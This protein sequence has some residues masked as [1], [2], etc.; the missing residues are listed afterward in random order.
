MCYE[1]NN[2]ANEKLR[3]IYRTPPTQRLIMSML[4]LT[5]QEK[6][7]P[8]TDSLQLISLPGKGDMNE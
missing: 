3:I 1:E 5:E 7:I 4:S 2:N 8:I 6:G